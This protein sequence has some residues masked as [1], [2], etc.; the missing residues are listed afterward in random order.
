MNEQNIVVAQT[1]YSGGEDEVFLFST[2]KLAEEYIFRYFSQVI[3]D[4]IV[5]GADIDDL[6]DYLFEYDIGYF[7]IYD[8]VVFT[9]KSQLSS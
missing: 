7:S 5:E 6:N 1:H 8:R 3:K 9:E 2:R 4:T